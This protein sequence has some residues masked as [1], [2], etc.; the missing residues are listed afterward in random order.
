MESFKKPQLISHYLPNQ[1]KEINGYLLQRKIGSGNF[2]EVFLAVKGNRNYAIKMYNHI[3][4]SGHQEGEYVKK[5]I[6]EEIRLLKSKFDHPN[7]IKVYEEFESAN[8]IYLVMDYFE[9]GDLMKKIS[10]NK[11]FSEADAVKALSD[12][13]EAMNH[14]FEKKV[15]HRDIKP[16][17]IL[18]TGNNYVLA[19]FGVAKICQN[20]TSTNVGTTPFMAPQILNYEKYSS[21]CDVWSLGI[22]I[23]MCLFGGD[24][25]EKFTIV[26][27]RLRPSEMPPP[28]RKN[29]YGSE[30]D[31]PDTPAISK[32]LRDILCQMLEEKENMRIS[33]P[34]LR[35]KLQQLQ[36]KASA[37]KVNIDL[38]ESIG[39][40]PV[41]A[42]SKQEIIKKEIRLLFI[43]TEIKAPNLPNN[44]QPEINL[45]VTLDIKIIQRF[46]DFNSR[47]C[48]LFLMA[49]NMLEDLVE[50]PTFADICHW[51]ATLRAFVCIKVNSVSRYCFERLKLNIPFTQFMA[52]EFHQN[53]FASQYQTEF[54]E[55]LCYTSRLRVEAAKIAGIKLEER[56][57]SD[58]KLKEDPKWRRFIDDLNKVMSVEIFHE[59]YQECFW[60]VMRRT[61]IAYNKNENKFGEKKLNF[62]QAFVLVY[63]AE[64]YSESMAETAKNN[65]DD[66]FAN[67]LA[68]SE[69]EYAI[70]DIFASA[71]SHYTKK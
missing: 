66:G 50:D 46:L 20:Y 67:L 32:P 12:I 24:P 51:I 52:H 60:S 11:L 40:E 43:D 65:Q 39:P 35:V 41:Q 6:Q 5:L 10:K 9:E 37:R 23:W 57:N 49:I 15:L 18:V 69:S 14:A 25:W 59:N 4:I 22:T 28:N 8:H 42:F 47:L 19:D 7:I 54:Y 34:D 61:V 55:H 1:K 58:P 33:W 63:L 62:K 71:N 30:L 36:G 68:L 38:Q 56:L 27:G 44:R 48:N 3:K 29:K 21:K 2:G 31:F 26:D 17:N 13:T 64:T 53:G 16:D 70:D 45:T